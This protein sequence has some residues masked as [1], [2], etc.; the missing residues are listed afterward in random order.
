MVGR[1]P[2]N[3]SRPLRLQQQHRFPPRRGVLPANSP[4]G[5]A[6]VQREQVERILQI[7]IR[8]RSSAGTAPGSPRPARQSG[9]RRRGTALWHLVIWPG[10]KKDGELFRFTP[11][12]DAYAHATLARPPTQDGQWPRVPRTVQVLSDAGGTAFLLRF[13]GTSSGTRYERSFPLAR[14]AGVGAVCIAGN[15]VRR[16]KSRCWRLHP[17]ALAGL[18]EPA[19]QCVPRRSLG[20]RPPGRC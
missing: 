8:G 1:L 2:E 17:A 6:A 14:N 19:R 11:L 7:Q 13:V 12:A 4:L 3:N 9:R 5:I 15:M 10:A 20:T 16:R 18:A